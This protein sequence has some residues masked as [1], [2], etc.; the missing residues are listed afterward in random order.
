MEFLSTLPVRGATILPVL[1]LKPVQVF[2]STL[3]VR[4]AT[5]TA[6]YRQLLVK[7]LSTL[8]VRGAT[9]LYRF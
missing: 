8:P 3:P 9:S 4:G 2:L 6:L 7:F 1:Y 5:K